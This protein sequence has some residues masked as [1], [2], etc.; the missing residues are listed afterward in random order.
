GGVGAAAGGPEGGDL[1]A[2]GAGRREVPGEGRHLAAGLADGLPG[3][4]TEPLLDDVGGDVGLRV[5]LPLDGGLAGV[6]SRAEVD[7]GGRGARPARAAGPGG[8]PPW[9]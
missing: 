8:R 1:V 7:V 3:P 4:V 6:V 2:V 5:R 9:P